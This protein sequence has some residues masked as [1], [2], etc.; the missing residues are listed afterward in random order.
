MPIPRVG[1]G[2]VIRNLPETLVG[3]GS[4]DVAAPTPSPRNLEISSDRASTAPGSRRVSAKTRHIRSTRASCLPPRPCAAGMGHRR[5]CMMGGVSVRARGSASLPHRRRHPRARAG[6]VFLL[7][8]LF[9]LR[10]TAARRLG[11][12][13]RVGP[14]KGR[15]SDAP[16]A[17]HSDYFRARMGRRAWA[18]RRSSSTRG[19][20]PRTRRE[21]VARGNESRAG[22]T[23]VSPS[24]VRP[25][26]ITPSSVI[27]SPRGENLRIAG[28]GPG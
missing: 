8:N 17:T 9:R 2:K 5:T 27:D 22:R 21:R 7:H 24:V 18:S 6:H 4:Y 13:S 1:G 16:W 26:R 12:R 15:G 14:A 28:E 20:C 3:T 25:A 10:R 11:R 23:I 19:T